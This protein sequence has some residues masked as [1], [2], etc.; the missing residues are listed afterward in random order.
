MNLTK[1]LTHHQ[2]VGDAD[3]K[4]NTGI[5]RRP[6]PSAGSL[7]GTISGLHRRC[8][9]LLPMLLLL[10]GFATEAT[11]QTVPTLKVEGDFSVTEGDS[12]TIRFTLSQAAS[13]TITFTIGD[14]INFTT[15]GA[16]RNCPADT[17]EPSASDYF[18]DGPK[19]ITFNIGDTTK[20]ITFM[21]RE[22]SAMESTEA[23]LMQVSG[24]AADE[25][26]IDP[27][28]PADSIYFAGPNWWVRILDDDTV[29]ELTITAADM[30]TEGSPASFTITANPTLPIDLTINLTVTEDETNGQNFVAAGDEGVQTVILPAGAGSVT[31]TIGTIFDNTIGDDDDG[32]LTVALATGTGYTIGTTTHTAVVTIT[33]NVPHVVSISPPTNDDE[34]DSGTENKFFTILLSSFHSQDISMRVCYSGTATRGAS[35][36]YQSYRF[37]GVVNSACSNVTM[38]AG[39]RNANIGIQIRGDTTAEPDETVIATLSLNNP[40]AGVVLGTSMATY[41]ILNDDV[42]QITIAADTASVAEGTSASFTITTNAPPADDLTIN[43]TVSEDEADGQN[44]VAAGDEGSKTVTIQAGQPSATYTVA[45]DDDST[46]ELSGAVTVT[47]NDGT[48][49][50]VGSINHTAVVTITNDDPYVVSVSI[51]PAA[52]DEGNSGGLTDAA[53]LTFTVN[54]PRPEAFPF[55]ICL[56]GGTAERGSSADYQFTS[57]NDTVLPIV[58]ASVCDS[59]LTTSFNSNQASFSTKIRVNGDSLFEADE[60]VTVSLRRISGSGGNFDTPDDV[61]L[62]PTAGSVTYTIRHDDTPPELTITP[63][64]TMVTEGSPASFTITANTFSGLPTTVNLMISEPGNFVDSDDKGPKSFLL[65]A[66]VDSARYRID[67]VPDNT[68]DDVENGTLTVT[69][70]DGDGYTVGTTTHTAVVTITNNVPHVVSVSIE[71]EEAEGDEGN[72]GGLTDAAT[73][74]F[75][76]NPPRPEGFRFRICLDGGTAESGSSADYQFTRLNDTVPAIA[77]VA[78]GCDSALE[79]PFNSNQA[80]FSQKIRVNGDSLFE[81][82]ETVTVSLQRVNNLGGN[83]DTPD[84][85]IISPTAGTVTYTIRNDDDPPMISIAGG[86]PAIEGAGT[87][88]Y[89]LTADKPPVTDLTINLTVTDVPGSDFIAAEGDQTVTFP[90]GRTIA[91]NYATIPITDD[92]V[93]EASGEVTVTINDGTGY[94]AGTDTATIRVLDDD[95]TIVTLAE[96]PAG[97]LDEDASKQITLTLNRGLVNGEELVV[98]LTFGGDATRG[99][100]YTLMEVAA[101]GVSYANLTGGDDP[102][103]TFTGPSSGTTAM[104]ATL[105]LRAIADSTSDSGESVTIVPG[106]LTDTSL[107]GGG[108]VTGSLAFNIIERVELILGTDRLMVSEGMQTASY[109]IRLASVPTAPVTVVVTGYVGTGL[110]LDNDELIFTAANWNIARQVTL[111]TAAMDSDFAGSTLQLRHTASGGNYLS[112]TADLSVTLLDDTAGVV[113]MPSGGN[114]VVSEDGARTD[115]YT[116]RLST[117]PVGD[118]VVRATA[119]TGLSVNDAATADLTFTTTNWN[120]AQ[121]VTIAGI[122]DDIASGALRTVS[123]THTIVNSADSG[124]PDALRIANLDVMLIDDDTTGLLLP[125][126]DLTLSEGDTI[127]YTVRLTSQPTAVVSVTITSDNGD[128]TPGNTPLMFSMDNWSMPQ[129]VLLTANADDD[130][131]DEQAQLTHRVAG[132]DYGAISE[133]ISVRITDRSAGV[134]ITQSGGNT[135]VREDGGE[136]S[137]T[138]VLN[139]APRGDVTLTVTAAAGITVDTDS[140]TFTTGNWQTPQPVTV[141]GVNDDLDNPDDGREVMIRHAVSGAGDSAGYTPALSIAPVSVT[142][143][144]DDTAGLRFSRSVL[145]VVEGGSTSYGVRLT[146]QPTAVVTVTIASD[147]GDLTAG[148]TPLMFST[149]NWP[150][151]QTV[152]V[153]AGT[154]SDMDNNDVALSHTATGGGYNSVS[155]TLGAMLLEGGTASVSIVQSDGRTIVTEGVSTDF[156]EV[157]LN[158]APD[159]DVTVRVNADSGVTVNGAATLDLVFTP[160]NWHEAQPVMVAAVDNNADDGVRTADISHI[161]SVG[162][163]NDYDRTLTIAGVTVT[164]NRDPDDSRGRLATISGG[165]QEGS[166]WAFN[167]IFDSNPG[168]SLGADE[169]VTLPLILGGD[170]VRGQDYQVRCERNPAERR[171]DSWVSCVES[172]DGQ[173]MFIL[174]GTRISPGRR[175]FRATPPLEVELLEDNMAEPVE[176]LT[177]RLGENGQDFRIPIMDVPS[178]VSVEFTRSIYRANENGGLLQ[179]VIEIS[180]ELGRAIDLPLLFIDGTAQ[181]GSDFEPISSTVLNFTAGSRASFDITLLDDQ[182]AE[183]DERFTVVIDETRLP[184]FI[185][186]GTNAAPTFIIT[187]NDERGLVFDSDTLTLAEGGTG[188]YTVRLSSQPTDEVAVVIAGQAG[189][190]LMLDR[191]ILTFTTAN[192]NQAQA[193]TV[194]AED[195]DDGDADRIVLVHTASGGDYGLSSRVQAD[196]IDSEAPEVRLNKE[197][198]TVSE[199]GSGDSYTLVLHTEPAGTVT[200]TLA[201]AAGITVQ[202]GS[203]TFTVD[204]WNTPQAVTVTGVNSDD[205]DRGVR[206]VTIVHTITATDDADDYPEDLRIDPVRVTIEEDDEAGVMIV[207]SGD[208]TAVSEDGGIRDDYTVVLT[209][210]PAARVVVTAT[211]AAGVSVDTQSLSGV[212]NTL[213]FTT[214]NWQSPQTVTV[215]GVDVD[216]VDRGDLDVSITHAITTTAGGYVKELSIDSV[217][218][219]V[220]DNDAANRLLFE[221]VDPAA[222]VL[223][224]EGSEVAYTMQLVGQPLADVTV[225]ISGHDGTD[226]TPAPTRL[227]F[228]TQNWNAGQTVTLT[229][230]ADD[231]GDDERV[232]LTHRASGGGY[233]GTEVA[234]EVAITD[235][236]I[237]GVSISKDTLVAIENE[238]GTDSYTVVLDIPPAGDVTIQIHDD[239]GFSTLVFTTVNWNQPQTVSMHGNNFADNIDNPGGERTTTIRHTV[240]STDSGYDGIEVDDVTVT[241]T[242]VDPT[243]VTLSGAALDVVEGTERTLTV[244]L[245]RAL[246]AGEVLP[247]PLTFA[248]TAT[249]GMD[250]TLEGVPATGIGYENLNSGNAQVT[251]TGGTGAVG[252]ATLTFRATPDADDEGSGETVT[253]GLGTL[254]E[255]SGTGL[256]GGGTGTSSLAPFRIIEKPMI[257]IAGGPAVTEGGSVTFTLTASEAPL[258][259]LTINLMVTDAVHSDFLAAARGGRQSITFVGGTTSVSYEIPTLADIDDEAGGTVMVA[260]LDGDGYVA[261]SAPSATTMVNDD[262]A[263]TVTLAGTDDDVGEGARKGLTVTLSR[264]LVAGEVLPVALSFAGTATRG[265]DYT[266]METIANGVSYAN[267]NGGGSATVTFTGPAAG[268]GV[269]EARL[270]LRAELDGTTEGLETVIIGLG[271]LDADSG[272]NLGGGATGVDELGDFRIQETPEIVLE[273]DSLMLTEQG[274]ATYTVGLSISPTA[275][276]TVRITGQVDT[277]LQ[278]DADT[279]IFSQTNWSTARTVTLTAVSDTDSE[280]EAPVMLRHTATGGNYGLAIM[281]TVT[282]S[283]A[284]NTP[285]LVLSTNSLDMEENEAESYTIR[286]AIRPMA[287]VTVSVSSGD[288][289]RLRVTGGDSLTFTPTNWNRAQSVTVMAEDDADSDANQVTL[290]HTA[291]AGYG[292]VTGDITVDIADD[293]IPRVVLGVDELTVIEGGSASYTVELGTRPSGDVMVT[294]SGQGSTLRPDRSELTFDASNWDQAQTITLTAVMDT[295]TDDDQVRLTH[296][297]S[298]YGADP[299]GLPVAITD[300][301]PQLMFSQTAVSVGE[302]GSTTYTLELSVE[303]VGP[304]TVTL[305]GHERTELTPEPTELFF[306][307]DNWDQAQIITLTAG[308]DSN[309]VDETITLTHSADAGYGAVTEEVTV[310]VRDA[311]TPRLILNTDELIEGG[312]ATYRVT[313]QGSATYTVRLGTQPQVDVTV[314][315]T[316]H[317]GS[318]LVPTPARLVFGRD[319]WNRAQQVTLTARDDDDS[320]NDAVTLSH[321]ASGGAYAGVTAPP[322]PLLIIDN[323][324]A[325][326]LS[327]VLALQP[328]GSSSYTMELAIVP[329]ADVIVTVMG[330]EDTGLTVA[331]ESLTF[332]MGNWNMAQTITVTAG[333]DSNALSNRVTLTHMASGGNYDRVTAQVEVEVRVGSTEAMQAAQQMWLPRF[334]LTAIEHMLGGLHHRFT[335]SDQPGL[336]GNLNGLPRGQSF[337]AARLLSSRGGPDASVLGIEQLGAGSADRPR[338]LSRTLSLPKLLPSM[339]RGSHFTLSDE[340]GTSIWGRA[341]YSSYKDADDG[342]SI[343]GEVTTAMLGV[344]HSSGRTLLGLALAYSDSDGEWQG[345]GESDK[346]ELSGTLASLLPYLRYDLTE[347]LQLWGAASYGRGD[348]EQTSETGSG[349]ESEHDL[350][351]VSATLGLRGTLLDRPVEEGGLSLKLTSDMTLARIKSDDSNAGMPG[352]P[353]VPGMTLDT[354]RFRMGLEWSWQLP[355]GGG[356]RLTPELELGLRY[357]GG[358]TSEGFGLE[359]GGGLNWQLPARGL[360]FDVRSRYL[361]EHEASGREE[362][363]LSGSLRYKARP[364]SAHGPSFSLRHEY[365]NAPAA[366]GLDRLLSDSLTDAL[367]ED[368]S[369]TADVSSRW[370]LKGEWGFALMDDATGIPYASLSAS[371]AKRDLT[372]G[373]RLLSNPAGLKS[374]LDI[375]A[376]R[377]EQDDNNPRHSVGAEWKLNW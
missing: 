366:S 155:A 364:D 17:S 88:T 341:S 282:V 371:D 243:T 367:K 40:P 263:T 127:S 51:D 311:D 195:D 107:D 241:V 142:V 159:R 65:P 166:R 124:Y 140:L 23:F 268:V 15:C 158:T 128:L 238:A 173:L 246:V 299:V 265:T 325:L 69:L 60:T 284:D 63:D 316:G 178:T 356:M 120:Q 115:D 247:V 133:V 95:R 213:T 177:L 292:S 363:G 187:D 121:T 13:S 271:T 49:Y 295:N 209:S 101:N 106:T 374:K 352:V 116:L 92:E 150:M 296:T 197:A 332:S 223:V 87:L 218:V 86:S 163:N 199:G 91:L 44:F 328:G 259:D 99:T 335:A 219:Q 68:L 10:L 351:Q 375:K 318:D 108:T 8:R 373:W 112:V 84:D 72:S 56:D 269:T 135:I 89:T 313:E 190:D 164:V 14:V 39:S 226:V 294:L 97:D 80:S 355:E 273:R 16:L 82:D 297:A 182:I 312:S 19:T 31:H 153:T 149:D 169:V 103:V 102:T 283:I 276:V 141:T 118:V 117:Q 36:D 85:V 358:D 43:L 208:R 161:L 307:P 113:V 210:Q 230:A 339:L 202:P 129:T 189:T 165:N 221:L 287:D 270:R 278:V 203:V 11:A 81:E 258:S 134:D 6:V 188:S 368:N 26:T 152:T 46:A 104:T 319:N 216:T 35:D 308:T 25:A 248:G 48:G 62:S 372:L 321:R 111:T 93:D 94:T 279:L 370:T 170:A 50:T 277:D 289:P 61:I 224:T 132:G 79:I 41:T 75:T 114:T 176:T 217:P 59:A 331:P 336:S 156:Y 252:T 4:N 317:E 344:D 58:V 38:S 154:D 207:E 125:S 139:A 205:I 172:T 18:F 286:L 342:T 360:T 334:G 126:S 193:V 198:I 28:T 171:S 119:G 180:P 349:I 266:L 350:E 98:P 240:T 146:S 147:N 148:N 131:D 145:A 280:D 174:D 32:T 168:R 303:P 256:N 20:S 47:L 151:P 29:P 30:V 262:D 298:G 254:D 260:L 357:D 27:T 183:G 64:A 78:G 24:L 71:P 233:D 236:D 194:M 320:V 77:P 272:T 326:V 314:T 288:A 42:P 340:D 137:Y 330:H 244:S 109:T 1:W 96:N 237:S 211:A 33:N 3:G 264:G 343:D 293:D 67:T 9:T 338:K 305:R 185:T 255:N 136:D 234:L 232:T 333:T 361:L 257:G 322:L 275:D 12:G 122:D 362:W 302:G 337:N 251:F 184:D 83:L 157:V 274:S 306:T 250:Y 160:T 304:V 196:I 281:R 66:G 53:T 2:P 181:A 212:Q 348:L 324:P 346:G 144:D 143:L 300:S 365:G 76:V 242:D 22:D 214:L 175:T 249:R 34:G 74:T 55:I 327:E 329:T 285:G 309:S 201:P 369:Q 191:D 21:T 345:Q 261:G 130:S 123:V 301:T 200:V 100:D 235:S 105:T 310:T 138:L 231:S 315:L 376:I 227:T 291:D 73:L 353:G 222:D 162:D 377:R 253:M 5:T 186:V 179:P 239:H 204:N 54:P 192:W 229:V 206:T 37:G 70:N 52:G 359:L 45:T 323:T 354:Q 267:L 290:T 7:A 57:L 225:D 167:F 110:M 245:E 347:R 228:T 215:T 90:A 220:I